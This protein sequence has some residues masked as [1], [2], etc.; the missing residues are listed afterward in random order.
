MK[1]LSFFLVILATVA[2]TSAQAAT[3]AACD[4]AIKAKRPC[5]GMHRGSPALSTCYTS[6]MQRCLKGGPSAI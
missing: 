5:A 6:A 4:A 3:R 2:C 1:I